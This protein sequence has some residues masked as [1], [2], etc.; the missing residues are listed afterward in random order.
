MDNWQALKKNIYF[1]DGSWR[2]IYIENTNQDD[3]LKW[4]AFI[5][6][7]Y[8]VSF[9]NG[10]TQQIEPR[11]DP[12]VVTAYWANEHEYGCS[13]TIY[14]AGISIKAHFFS[15]EEIEN[16]IDPKDI[17]SLEDH[18]TIIHYLRQLRDLTGKT[19]CLT[20]ENSKDRP[21]WKIDAISTL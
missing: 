3:W 21:L 9:Y 6:E 17:K 1:E 18:Y 14:S 8:S 15:P 11:I 16:D 20:E 10:P 7:N 13:A 5:N 2:D 19:V 4:I 12:E